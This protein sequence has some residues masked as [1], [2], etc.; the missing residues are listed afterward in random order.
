MLKIPKTLFS[1]IGIA[2]L[3]I[4]T[5]LLLRGV[6]GVYEKARYAKEN[7]E[8]A[9]Q[10]LHELTERREVLQEEITRLNTKRGLEEELRQKFDVGRE[11][12]QLVVLVDPPESDTPQEE[13]RK[14]LWQRIV[15]FFGIN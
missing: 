2:V 8:R 7:R 10:E 5:A 12:E 6:W 1:R 4:L 13:P 3:L 9:E 11:G 14:T 15:G